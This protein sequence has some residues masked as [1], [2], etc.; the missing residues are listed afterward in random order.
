MHRLGIGR[1]HTRTPVIIL[2]NADTITVTDRAIGEILSEHF[3]NPDKKY[4]PKK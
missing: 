2:T 4:W 1:A 3:I